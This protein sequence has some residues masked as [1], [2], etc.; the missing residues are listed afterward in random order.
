MAKAGGN[1]WAPA[2]GAEMIPGAAV[3]QGEEER[4]QRAKHTH[5]HTRD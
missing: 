3:A 2:N 1:A 4:D 5:T